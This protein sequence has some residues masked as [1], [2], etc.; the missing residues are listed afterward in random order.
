MPII[1]RAVTAVLA[2]A[3]CI[4]PAAAQKKY[5]PGATDSEIKLGQ[6]MPYSGPL[7]GFI[8][9]AKAE[10]AYFAMINEQGG[11]NGRKITMISLDDGYSPPKTVEQTRRLVEET[12]AAA[13]SGS[14]APDQCGGA[15]IAQQEGAAALP[16]VGRRPPTTPRI[17]LHHD[18]DADL[19]G[20]GRHLCGLPAQG[21][22]GP[23]V[24]VLCQNDDFDGFYRRNFRD[25]LATRRRSSPRSELRSD[26]R[27]G[28]FRDHRPRRHQGQRLLNISTPKFAAGD[29]QGAR[30]G[31]RRYSYQQL[32]ASIG[33]VMRRPASRHQE[34]HLGCLREGPPPAIQDDPE[35]K[36]WAWM[37]KYYPPQ[38]QD[39]Q[40]WWA[41]AG[42][43]HGAG[44]E[45]VRHTHDARTS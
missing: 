44:A 28:R 20:R 13:I 31:W 42:P 1:R 33:I 40:T 10:I 9:L 38:L 27:H 15:E 30:P 23:R 17:F 7:S 34:H 19:R 29:P 16:G 21:G 2:S 11:V 35:F 8:T 43:G 3:L 32:A 24:A 39:P 22:Q 36:G 12:G 4:G 5:D 14:P 18:A 45:A 26:R 25:R 37:Q 6:T 41:H